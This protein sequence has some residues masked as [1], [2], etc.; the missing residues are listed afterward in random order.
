MADSL[1][2]KLFNT[3]AESLKS[4]P[5]ELAAEVKHQVAAGSHELAA[6]LFNGSGFVMYGRNGRE[7]QT[8]EHGLDSQGVEPI[9]QDHGLSM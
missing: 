6:C 7:D 9:K 5:S 2:D 3:V 4:A 8:P 1:A